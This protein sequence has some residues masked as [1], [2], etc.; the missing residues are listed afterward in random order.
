MVDFN[1]LD[2]DNRIN[3]TIVQLA[4]IYLELYLLT[5]YRY[6]CPSDVRHVRSLPWNILTNE[7]SLLEQQWPD[8][9][10]RL[11]SVMI[12]SRR[13]KQQ[14]CWRDCI[15]VVVF[16]PTF[17]SQ[18]NSS[19]IKNKF[20]HLVLLNTSRSVVWK[21]SLQTHSRHRIHRMLQYFHVL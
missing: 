5:I 19:N 14:G 16:L 20:R 4:Y 18:D 2:L 17:C 13:P 1:G 11:H 10:Y 21:L 12:S 9:T 3:F 8:Y 7:L 15:V 6:T